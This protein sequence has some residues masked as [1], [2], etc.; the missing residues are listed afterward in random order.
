MEEVVKTEQPPSRKFGEIATL[1]C[2]G[3]SITF[4]TALIG[5]NLTGPFVTFAY[6]CFAAA[7][8]SLVA[9]VVY[10][11][12]IADYEIQHF[13]WWLKITTASAVFEVMFGVGGT[14]YA[15]DVRVGSVFA[16]VS[17]GLIYAMSK[18]ETRLRKLNE[19][20]K[21]PAPTGD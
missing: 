10:K 14:F 5:S 3:V 4:V 17:V 15:I 18:S 9:F 6:C 2:L 20:K 13:P 7:V 19:K 11:E 16:F 21:D 8:P 1:A 12:L